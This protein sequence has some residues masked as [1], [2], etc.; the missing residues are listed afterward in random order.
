[1]D[2]IAFH[3]KEATESCAGSFAE[4][5]DFAKVSKQAVAN[6]RQRY[7]NFPRPLQHLQSGPVWGREVIEAWVKNFKGVETPV[8]S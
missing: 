7:D 2:K 3:G 8:L 4:I 6:W 5:A 1:V